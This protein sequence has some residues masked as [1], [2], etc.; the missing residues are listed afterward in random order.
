MPEAIIE[1]KALSTS[2]SPER[3][4]GIRDGRRQSQQSRSAALPQT[5]AAVPVPGALVTWMPGWSYRAGLR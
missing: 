2:G 4:T 3:S 5:L 1:S